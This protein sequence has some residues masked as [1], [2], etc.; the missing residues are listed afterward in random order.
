MS[1]ATSFGNAKHHQHKCDQAAGYVAM[2]RDLERWLETVTGYAAVS[3]QP[4]AG[5]QG[6]LAGLLAIRK[7]MGRC[8]IRGVVAAEEELREAQQVCSHGTG[9]RRGLSQC[10]QIMVDRIQI[11]G[12]GGQMV[13]F[14]VP[15]AL[16][17]S[18]IKGIVRQFADAA[19]RAKD[20][21]LD[22]IELH[23]ANCYLIKPA[24]PQELVLTAALLLGDRAAAL[25]AAEGVHA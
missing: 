19:R 17:T 7:A 1:E 8:R 24:K 10:I 22:G 12:L 13:D 14:A 3:L 18:E 5:S 23:G 20:A 11:A 21:G 15:R 9:F 16:E 6:E 25:K 2:I 4:N